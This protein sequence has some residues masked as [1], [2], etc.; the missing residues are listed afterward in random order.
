M[1]SRFPAQ[2]HPNTPKH[3][4]IHH[5]SNGNE[6]KNVISSDPKIETYLGLE[7]TGLKLSHL[8]IRNRLPKIEE[9]KRFTNQRHN[10]HIFGLCET[11][12]TEMVTNNMI[13]IEDFTLER[14]D[15]CETRDK[16]GGGLA[17]YISNSLNHKRRNDLEVSNLESV[18]L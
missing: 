6:N 14:K 16:L 7:K 11:I 18:W 17:I 3:T 13:N 10:T 9:I 15:R 4:Q 12:L 1:A 5:E 8:N 2:I